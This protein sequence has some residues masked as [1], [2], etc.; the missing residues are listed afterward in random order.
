MNSENTLAIKMV[1][2]FEQKR[3]QH[4]QFK[5]MADTSP[6]PA[7][8]CDSEGEVAYVNKAYTSLTGVTLQDLQEGVNGVGIALQDRSRINDAL[9]KYVKDANND[10]YTWEEYAHL[11]KKDGTVVR[12]KIAMNKIPGDGFVGFASPTS[13]IFD[14]ML[15]ESLTSKFMLV[16]PDL[17]CILDDKGYF[18]RAG[19][20]W[21]R[22][23]YTDYELANIEWKNFVHP[24]DINNS[25]KAREDTKY[26]EILHFENRVFNKTTGKY[27]NILWSASLEDENKLTFAT[28]RDMGEIC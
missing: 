23:G 24:D 5:T 26:K 28:G 3:V 7:F 13:L 10:N 4:L 15:F 22:W 9:A 14:T 20:A 2:S 16:S 6:I 27:H 1:E 11:L 19:K 21:A 25:L 12:A 18:I 8:M 17:T